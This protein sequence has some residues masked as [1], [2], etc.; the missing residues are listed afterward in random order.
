MRWNNIIRNTKK[1][2][3]R[4]FGS[5]KYLIYNSF[6]AFDLFKKGYSRKR[7]SLMKQENIRMALKTN[8]P[9]ALEVHTDL[10]GFCFEE[11]CLSMT[12]RS[13]SDCE[14]TRT[15]TR[16]NQSGFYDIMSSASAHDDT[17]RFAKAHKAWC[18]QL[19]LWRKGWT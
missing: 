16:C 13:C 19:G 15:K 1:E 7:L 3:K 18:K 6:K 4:G 2:N 9:S 17:D 10:C 14:L 8:H 12:K 11:D 5:D